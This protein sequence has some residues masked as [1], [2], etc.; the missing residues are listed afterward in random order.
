[1]LKEAHET[2]WSNMIP[3]YWSY[4]IPRQYHGTESFQPT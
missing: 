3:E 2:L 1:M 4:N